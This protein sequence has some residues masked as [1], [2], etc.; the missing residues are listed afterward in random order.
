LYAYA[1]GNPVSLTDQFGLKT[2]LIT[3][4]DFGIGSHSALHVNVPGQ[5][6]FLYDPGGSYLSKVK[7]SG[8][9]FYGDEANLAK[10]FEYQK[11]ALG[12]IEWVGADCLGCYSSCVDL[13]SCLS[14]AC[15]MQ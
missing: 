9:F 4:Y 3:T 15:K 8:G 14:D 7:G 10:Y 1:G 12:E 13:G 6:P 2:T 11:S 5:Q